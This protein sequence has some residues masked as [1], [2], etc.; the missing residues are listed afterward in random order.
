MK[1]LIASA[2]LAVLLST[3]PCSLAGAADGPPPKE[4]QDRLAARGREISRLTKDE[5]VKL[6]LQLA[7]APEEF[8]VVL[9]NSYG[10]G[11]NY[12]RTV[13]KFELLLINMKNAGYNT[14]HGVY[15]EWRAPLCRRHGVKM[16]IDILAWFN[17]AQQDIRDPR[18]WQ[19][20][21]VKEICE[22]VRNDRAVWGYNLWNE[23]IHEYFRGGGDMNSHHALIKK[24]DGTHPVWIG[25][26]YT[27]SLGWIWGNPGVVGFYDYHWARG[28]GFHYGHMNAY[29][30]FAEERQ[31]YMGRWLYVHDYRRNMY[32]L[33]TSI[34][35]GLKVCMWFIG[36]V[37]DVKTQT[38]NDNHHFV[39]IG[40]EMRALY[41][42]L[43]KIGRPICHKDDAG[44]IRSFEVYSTPLI[45][46]NT[47]KPAIDPGTKKPKIIGNWR[48]FPED[49]WAQVD[50]GSVVAGFFKYPNADDAIYVANH[51]ALEKDATNVVLNFAN[52]RKQGHR[53]FVVGLFDRKRGKWKELA[54]KNDC[55]TFVLAPAGGE[56]L[57]VGSGLRRN[58]KTPDEL[59]PCD[60]TI[61]WADDALQVAWDLEGPD[62]EKAVA[63]Y[64]NVATRFRGKDPAKKAAERLKLIEPRLALETRAWSEYENLLALSK[65]LKK[66]AGQPASAGS[67]TW[68]AADKAVTDRLLRGTKGLYAEL[69]DTMGA[70][71]AR[72]L[73]EK[74]EIA[75]WSP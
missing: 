41:P 68:A 27:H 18:M 65:Q 69:P 59:G 5:K 33:N 75:D 6:C 24:W 60:G 17:D 7:P 48:A 8:A 12:P 43:A 42:E 10:G 35:H 45:D 13:A 70:C 30:Q 1:S 49:H 51:Q 20:P 19:R 38:W 21:R 37:W 56:L 36:R 46:R 72:E 16:M 9:S 44:K 67:A 31:S 47:G 54:L 63:L 2:A 15:R 4:E 74:Y 57:A 3:S 71:R 58:R 32:T 62:L 39:R 61:R 26:K 55:V 53:P 64:R 28:F 14:L 29:T 22:R 11:D 34:A 66:V 23:P 50:N 52:R 25:T 40:R 73:C